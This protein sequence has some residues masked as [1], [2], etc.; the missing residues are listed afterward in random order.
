MCLYILGYWRQILRKFGI[1]KKILVQQQTVN[2]FHLPCIFQSQNILKAT[3]AL[4]HWWCTLF[5]M[6]D[7]F[8]SQYMMY[9]I[10]NI[11]CTSF[12]IYDVFHSQYMVYF[13]HN[14]WCISVTIH[15][16]FYSNILYISFTIL[17]IKYVTNVAVHLLFLYILNHSISFL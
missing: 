16:V 10:Y 3:D 7:V 14:I 13:I 4:Q 5:T 1:H 15:D 9:F 12:T 11:W 6:Y 2:I 8:Y 17:W